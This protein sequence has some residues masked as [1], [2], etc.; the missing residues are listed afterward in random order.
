MGI[1]CTIP[2]P[3]HRKGLWK[4]CM[5]LWT[6]IRNSTGKIILKISCRHLSWMEG[7]INV[8][9][10]SAC[11]PGLYERMN[12]ELTELLRKAGLSEGWW[13]LTGT[14]HARKCL[15]IILPGNHSSG[16]WKY[17]RR[18]LLKNMAAGPL[19]W[20]CPPD[21]PDSPDTDLPVLLIFP[22]EYPWFR[23]RNGRKNVGKCADMP[24]LLTGSYQ[25]PLLNFVIAH[26]FSSD[27]LQ[28]AVTNRF[29]LSARQWMHQCN[30]RNE[31]LYSV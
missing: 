17:R 30:K 15:L 22:K 4:T 5:T 27:H 14:V 21:S 29:I 26:I 2:H 19:H 10:L 20:S 13:K 9:P 16:C 8:L 23:L 31:P 11:I 18:K 12:W 1:L 24:L 3:W 25:N 28:L 7:C 6:L